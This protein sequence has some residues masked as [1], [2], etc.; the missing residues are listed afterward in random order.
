MFSKI[1]HVGYQVNNLEQAVSW[2]AEKFGATRAAGGP[3]QLGGRNAFVRFGQIEV[4]LLEPRVHDDLP[5]DTLLMHHVGYVVPD[6]QKAAAKLQQK[7]LEFTADQPNVNALGQQVL[8]L[9]P[10]TTN[11]A[12][13]HLTQLPQQPHPIGFGQGL[14]ID[15]I[16]HAGYVVDDLAEAVAWYTDKFEGRYIGGGMSRRGVNNAFVNFGQVQV[17]LLEPTSLEQLGGRRHAMDHVGY[18]VPDILAGI[19]ECQRR[20]LRLGEA[21]PRANSINQQLCYFDTACTCGTQIHLT[22]LP[23]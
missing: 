14:A 1:Q 3:A 11:D 6:L 4:E 20:G 22:Q 19:E 7:G 9:D 2:F 17:E 13:I 8:W 12:L 10:A 21:S 16:I 15:R 23:D 5:E 18:V